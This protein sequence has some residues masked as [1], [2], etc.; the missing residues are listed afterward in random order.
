MIQR[1]AWA[2]NSSSSGQFANRLVVGRNEF[3]DAGEAS[4]DTKQMSLAFI[5]LVI[6]I[7]R[8][9]DWPFTVNHLACCRRLAV[10]H[11]RVGVT[12]NA[13]HSLLQL[14]SPPPRGS[15]LSRKNGPELSEA[16]YRGWAAL[17][18]IIR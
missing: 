8:I 12:A 4:R 6:V 18:L 15:S 11:L 1:S 13:M 7:Y 2:A 3:A 5:K 14:C 17:D 10:G 16:G 9:I